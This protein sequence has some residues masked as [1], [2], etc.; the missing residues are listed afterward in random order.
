MEEMD[1]YYRKKIKQSRKYIEWTKLPDNSEMKY[2]TKIYRKPRDE[3]ELLA[4]MKRTIVSN[5][6][7]KQKKGQPKYPSLTDDELLEKVRYNEV[8]KE[9]MTLD[10][11]QMKL[12]D[13]KNYE[14]GNEVHLK[15]LMKRIST[16]M[17][18]NKRRKLNS[19]CGD[20]VDVKIEKRVTVAADS[21]VSDVEN[22]RRNAAILLLNLS[23]RGGYVEGGR[24][25]HDLMRDGNSEDETTFKNCAIRTVGD[26]GPDEE[27][28][29][30]AYGATDTV[31]KSL[32]AGNDFD[33]EKN[34][35]E[36]G[37]QSNANG[38]MEHQNIMSVIAGLEL[39]G[40]NRSVDHE[41]LHYR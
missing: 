18:C 13:C 6:K 1:D 4:Q 35:A 14:R 26:A 25:D 32:S 2:S 24:D 39:Q 8:Y 10:H 33:D 21:V 16:R 20:S 40:E 19:A 7:A 36:G 37:L 22:E 17:T 3:I 30:L 29:T 31:G 27:E 12:Y 15:Q 34:E 11:G 9:Y 23:L 38:E 5:D 28:S 41:K